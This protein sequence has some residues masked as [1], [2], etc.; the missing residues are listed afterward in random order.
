MA[1]ERAAQPRLSLTV[2]L[3]DEVD[4]L[5]AP[6]S[7]LRR[8]VAACI[9]SDAQIVLRFVGEREGRGLNAAYRG[10][11]YATNVLTFAYDEADGLHADIV[12]CLPV[13][14]R[15]ARE[16]RKPVAAHL[17]HLVAHGVLHAGGYEHDTERG[18][19]RMQRRESEL[20]ARFRLPDPWG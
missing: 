18:A 15:E 14:R 9:E 3:G 8:W 16:Q 4:A 6:R 19:Q 10:R 7:R 13:V 11:D 12:I 20:L 5:P 1:A 17:A 2:Q